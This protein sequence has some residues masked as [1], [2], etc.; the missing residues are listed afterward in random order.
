MYGNELSTITFWAIRSQILSRELPPSIP[1][2]FLGSCITKYV[3]VV[4]L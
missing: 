4:S 3:H 2:V 1:S